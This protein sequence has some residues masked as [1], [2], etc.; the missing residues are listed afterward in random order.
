MQSSHASSMLGPAG[1][2]LQMDKSVPLTEV[3]PS[4]TLTH[5]PYTA[6]P[7]DEH[8]S[9][10][11]LYSNYNV[12]YFGTQFYYSSLIECFICSLPMLSES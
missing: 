6:E 2:R 4:N 12:S 8:P 1:T 10:I 3:T 9:E 7:T 11:F 5:L